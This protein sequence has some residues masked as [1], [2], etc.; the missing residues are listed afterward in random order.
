MPQLSVLVYVTSIARLIEILL[1]RTLPNNYFTAKN[2]N[3]EVAEV[4]RRQLLFG[5]RGIKESPVSNNVLENLRNNV[6]NVPNN[7]TETTE[8]RK[9]VLKN[10]YSK[11]SSQLNNPRTKVAFEK[12][13]V[14]ISNRRP[15]VLTELSLFATDKSFTTNVALKYSMTIFS[16]MILNSVYHSTLCNLRK[17]KWCLNK[18]TINWYTNFSIKYCKEH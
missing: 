14:R 12:F 1:H 16:D 9:S 10:V 15:D 7:V 3:Q 4:L 18:R 6:L 11:L 17:R 8:Q 5:V 2:P 13:R